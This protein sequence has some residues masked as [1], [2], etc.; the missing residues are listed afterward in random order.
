MVGCEGSVLAGKQTHQASMTWGEDK[1]PHENAPTLKVPS[2]V[3]ISDV[4]IDHQRVD[5]A[6]NLYRWSSPRG[7]HQ[8]AHRDDLL[9]VGTYLIWWDTIPYWE[10]ILRG[11]V[12]GYSMY[13]HELIEL[14]WYF[15]QDA[16]PFDFQEQT[17]GYREAHAEAL[18][19]EHRFL[20]TAARRMRHTFSLRELII[21]NPHGD[22]LRDN[23]EG[24]WEVVVARKRRDLSRSDRTLRASSE[25]AVLEF[26]TCLGFQKA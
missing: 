19:Y 4:P 14:D 8:W 11:G 21:Y 22:P 23:W 17:A 15:T 12:R 9:M 13:L 20:Q 1:M 2:R 25:G 5:Q 16:D 3:R 7:L 26:Y 24:D 10:I 18:L 6:V